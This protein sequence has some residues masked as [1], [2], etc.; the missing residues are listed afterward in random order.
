MALDAVTIHLEGDCAHASCRALADR[1]HLQFNTPKLS[2]G[3]A[4]MPVPGSRTAWEAEHRTARKRAWRAERLGYKFAEV[5]WGPMNDDRL[6]INR[7]KAIRQGRPMDEAYLKDT[8]FGPLKPY[9]CD[10][11]RI[12]RF[13]ILQGGR[14]RAYATLYRVGELAIVST[15]LGHGD[16]EPNGIMFLLGAGMVEHQAGSGGWFVYHRWDGGLDGLRFLKARL[17]FAEENVTWS[18]T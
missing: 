14:L 5:D 18:L 11:H 8:T 4:L 10:R 6:E 7:S 3:V 2:R 9:P 17:G 16:H 12:H 1:I 13:G 15:I